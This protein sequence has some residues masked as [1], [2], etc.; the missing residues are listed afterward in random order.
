MIKRH[1]PVADIV[2]DHHELEYVSQAIA[3]KAV[4]G[5]FGS[6]I[7]RFEDEFSAFVGC[8]FGVAVSSGTTA[9]HLALLALGIG[10]GDEVL[11]SAYTNMATYFPVLYTGAT[12]VPVDV[13]LGTWNID[14]M[15][16]EKLVTH[17]T[18]AII[19]VH[20]FGHP[21]DMDPIMEVARKHNLAVIEDCAEAHGAIYNGQPVGSI[22]NIGCFS[23]YAN[24]II[25]TGEGG[26]VTTNDESVAKRIASLKSLAFG[27][28]DKF[29][30]CAVG[31]NYRMT[32]L[33]AA[34][35]CAQMTKIERLIEGKRKL[36]AAYNQRLK[37]TEHLRLPIE[38]H[39]AK[40]VYW[41]YHIVLTN[42]GRK[43]R[44]QV[45]MK[46]QEH[47]IETRTG[48]IPYNMQQ[49]FIERGMT[50]PELCPVANNLAFNA[51]YLPSTPN[52]P[53]AD[54]DYITDNLLEVLKG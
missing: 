38:K 24:K 20:I 23:F 49:I 3:E 48:F 2:F 22:G 39:Y 36:A 17:Q 26:M 32:N 5:F 35:G 42:N 1:I 43:M 29:M 53:V 45:M 46:L 28:E 21:A 12:P 31:Y 14:P 6:F 52:M 16:V 7:K 19:V 4:S 54:I 25:T 18:R 44:N 10:A 30:H 34:L 50:A 8:R 27:A 51:F 40:N 9:I 13:E 41:M 11:V 47:G 37:G 33:Q 15:Q